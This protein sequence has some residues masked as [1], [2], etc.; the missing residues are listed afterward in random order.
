MHAGPLGPARSVTMFIALV[1]LRTG[2]LFDHF[3]VLSHPSSTSLG[4]HLLVL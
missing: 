4:I 3:V 2:A 1:S